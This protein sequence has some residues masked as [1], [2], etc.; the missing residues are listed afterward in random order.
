MKGLSFIAA[1]RK[2]FAF[3]TSSI[4]GSFFPE[5]YNPL[6]ALIGIVVADIFGKSIIKASKKSLSTSKERV[7]K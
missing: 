5:R 4:E 7:L 2:C 3:L 6:I 1:H